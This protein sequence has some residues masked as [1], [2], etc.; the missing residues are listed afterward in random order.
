[1]VFGRDRRFKN[2]RD[3]ENRNQTYAL[4]SSL[5]RQVDSK[6]KTEAKT[7]FARS[8]RNARRG[9]FADPQMPRQPRIRLSH[10]KY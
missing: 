9:F 4:Y 5:G 1:M 7:K 8:G 6:K 2:K 3:K 10:A